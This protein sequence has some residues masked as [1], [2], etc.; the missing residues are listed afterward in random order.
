MKVID[1]FM[2]GTCHNCHLKFTRNDLYPVENH[3]E[4]ILTIY[5][6]PP[7]VV[8]SEE[9]QHDKIQCEPLDLSQ[10][11]DNSPLL[12]N[13]SS[14]DKLKPKISINLEKVGVSEGQHDYFFP[15]QLF[16]HMEA[17]WVD[18]IP[19]DIDGMKLYKLRSNI[20]DYW[21]VSSDLHHFRMTTSRVGTNEFK[22]KTGKCLG[23]LFC[24]NKDCTFLATNAHG[25]QNK[26]QWNNPQ[27]GI[28]TCYSCDTVA[29]TTGCP[30]RKMT[31]FHYKSKILT[32]YHLGNHVCQKKKDTSRHLAMATKVVNENPG[33]GPVAGR[34]RSVKYTL[35]TQGVEAAYKDAEESN[36]PAFK[37]AKRNLT[38]EQNPNQHSFEAVA[39]YREGLLK[40]DP[41]LI[42]KIN[43]QSFNGDPDYVFK[44]ST[45]MA[46]L[47][48]QMD[49]RQDQHNPLMAEEAY[50]DGAHKRCAGFK[51]LGLFVYHPALRKILKLASMEVRKE[52]TT[53]IKLFWQL[54]NEVLTKVNGKP[55]YFNPKGI[56]VD[57]AGPNYCGVK[58]VFGQQYCDDKV[59]GCQLHYK[60]NVHLK[61][62]RIPESYKAEFV[63]NCFK[64]C[65]A[66]TVS[67]YNEVKTCLDEFAQQ[68]PEIQAWLN[69]WDARKYH[70]FTPFRR[71]G[72]A[73]VTFAEAGQSNS[74]RP[75]NLW[76]LEACKDDVAAM[77]IQVA[78]IKGFYNQTSSV[79]GKGLT[80]L[81][82]AGMA[83]NKQIHIAKTLV[84]ELEDAECAVA[85]YEEAVNGSK[86]IPSSGCKHKP[87]NKNSLQGTRKKKTSKAVLGLVRKRKSTKAVLG[88]D[89][90]IQ[91]AHNI[92]HD[93]GVLIEAEG[94][95]PCLSC[96][97]NEEIICEQATRYNPESNSPHVALFMGLNISRCKGCGHNINRTIYPPP[98]NLCFR[99]QGVRKYTDRSLNIVR[100][101]WGNI[102]FHLDINCLMHHHPDI[103]SEHLTVAKDTLTMLT[104]GNLK[105]LKSKG[106]LQYIMAN[107]SK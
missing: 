54:F 40:K 51:T 55:T 65:S 96:R 107:L 33:A 15:R 27:K 39:I 60:K 8:N 90:Q 104:E 86:F 52:D 76:L 83:R 61:S 38:I 7:E 85:E 46:Q 98:A 48:L 97:A 17:E 49:Q 99:M 68:F 66:V 43:Q 77:I 13:L 2:H 22:R 45:E 92:L 16:T 71:Y 91:L 25:N 82:K 11:P 79:T 3:Y 103:K 69:W 4:P 93:G 74:Q 89:A 5:T 81:Q 80:S 94:P 19:P 23:N 57:E 28:K 106:F 67:K 101:K 88:L 44:T 30:A 18:Y 26:S 36:T 14:C 41:F 75:D 10:K 63:Y 12:D 102:Y 50:F 100:S 42:Y 34:K 78:D 95:H 9:L 35:D 53:N 24:P 1:Q 37:N 105:F 84:K 72:Y 70:V 56:M 32:V 62:H 20:R 58:E 59:V 47:A 31:E 21:K 64:L 29:Q 6:P 87:T 73:N